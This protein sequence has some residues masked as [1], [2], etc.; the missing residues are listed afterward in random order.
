MAW[1]SGKEATP[2]DST[3]S[4]KSDFAALDRLLK[5]FSPRPQQQ[6][7]AA[8][9]ETTLVSGRKAVIEA[10]TGVGKSLAYLIPAARWATQHV[11][12][13]DPPRH[14]KVVVA[15]YT[16][17]LQHQLVNKD[18]PIVRD[19]LAEE[20]I[21][22]DFSLL[23]G[24]E[25]YLCLQ[26]LHQTAEGKSDLLLAAGQSH[27][28]AKIDSWTPKAQSGLRNEVPIDVPN[29]LWNCI[30][31]DP[32]ICLG[33]KGPYWGGCLYRKDVERARKAHILVVNHHLLLNGLPSWLDFDALIIDEAHNLEDVA[34]SIFGVSISSRDVKKLLDDTFNS[35]TKRGLLARVRGISFQQRREVRGALRDGERRAKELFDALRDKLKLAAAFDIGEGFGM[36]RVQEPRVVEDTLSPILA[37]V[38]RCLQK[39]LAH[40]ASKEEEAQIAAMI[41]RYA[42]MMEGL[43]RFFACDD[44]TFAYWV[45]LRKER[46]LPTI[47]LHVKPIEVAKFIAEYLFKR[48]YPVALTSATIS[49]DKNLDSFKGRIGIGDCD[50]AIFD[51]PFDYSKNVRIFRPQ[52]FP[53]PSNDEIEHLAMT[54]ETCGALADSVPGGILFLFTSWKALKDAASAA[55]LARLNRPIFVQGEK[56]ADKLLS[57]FRNAG[58]GLLFATD[59]FWQGVDVP[60]PALSCL[61][62]SRLPFSPPGTPLEQARTDLFALRGLNYFRHYALPKAVIKFR[63][64]FGRLIRSETDRGVVVILD[65]RTRTKPYGR[66]FLN[67]IPH[68]P[69]I[70]T[71][72]EIR[73]FFAAPR[74]ADSTSIEEVLIAAVARNGGKMKGRDLVDAI[75]RPETRKGVVSTLNRLIDSGRLDVRGGLVCIPVPPPSPTA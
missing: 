33:K 57:E 64:G 47:S 10:G 32:E 7:M 38:N 68:S 11:E 59:T 15:T 55:R 9:V 73:A 12:G 39:S 37:Q 70:A 69:E 35:K 56:E 8:K 54:A 29:S 71:P 53:D 31:R 28:L 17:A 51:S 60:G 67:S 18:L 20:G 43:S 74:A 14:R 61:V 62:L 63:Q 25:N 5:G 65:P 4:L 45:E 58:N 30:N 16:K 52:G 75:S 24:S 23:M 13:A 40:A 3:M 49:V 2:S 72:A 34:T 22:L 36:K 46:N 19:L 1:T 42:T 21:S 44:Q 26:R 66:I 41:K 27:L 48:N 6:E 50:E